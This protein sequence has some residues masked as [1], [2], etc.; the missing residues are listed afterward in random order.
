MAGASKHGDEHFEFY[1]E[2]EVSY[3]LGDCQLLKNSALWGY[4]DYKYGYCIVYTRYKVATVKQTAFHSKKSERNNRETA[5]KGV[6]YAVLA[7][8]LWPRK[9][10][11]L[12]SCEGACEEKT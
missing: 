6:F 1:E 5:G 8:K 4:A 7:E 3:Q 12:V 10:K 11:K 2:V 9:V